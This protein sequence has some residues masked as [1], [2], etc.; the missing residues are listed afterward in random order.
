MIL[1]PGDLVCDAFWGTDGATDP[2][3]ILDR[4]KLRRLYSRKASKKGVVYVS[5]SAVKVIRLSKQITTVTK[6][7]VY[8]WSVI[9]RDGIK[10]DIPT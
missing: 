8:Q 7:T 10:L 9:L 5:T 4:V 6:V 3:L 2:M 1:E